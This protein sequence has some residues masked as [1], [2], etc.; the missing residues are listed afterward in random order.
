MFFLHHIRRVLVGLRFVLFT[1]YQKGIDRFKIIIIMIIII[2]INKSFRTI[3]FIVISTTFQPICP[4][5]FF[6]CLSNPGIYTELRTTP[7]IESTGVTCSDSVNRNRVQVLR[8]SLL[9]LACSQ[10]WTCILLRSLGNSNRYVMCPA[11][12]FRLNFGGDL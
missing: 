5:A 3:V 11:G 1:L 9:F 10:D 7:F 2:I 4:P 8:I 12:Q 6:R